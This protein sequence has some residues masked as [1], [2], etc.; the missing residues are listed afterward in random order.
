MASDF[1][2]IKNVEYDQNTAKYKFYDSN[3]NLIANTNDVI[4]SLSP[5]NC[6]IFNIVIDNPEPDR[7]DK[8]INIVNSL[9]FPEKS[10]I[11]YVKP[12]Q[13]P[14]SELLDVCGKKIKVDFSFKC[15]IEE[16][17][18]TIERK[19]EVKGF[20]SLIVNNLTI[21][22][23]FGC[24]ISVQLIKQKQNII[25]MFIDF[26]DDILRDDK[27]LKSFE[28]KYG[29]INNILNDNIEIILFDLKTISQLLT[30]EK[31]ILI[32]GKKIGESGRDFLK[33]LTLDIWAYKRSDEYVVPR[34]IKFYNNK[35]VRDMMIYLNNLSNFTK[36]KIIM[37]IDYFREDFNYNYEIGKKMGNIKV[38][39]DLFF[40]GLHLDLDLKED[41]KIDEEHVKEI[42]E[43]N[44]DKN[45][46]NK[47]YEDFIEY[48]SK[49]GIKIIK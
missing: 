32:R 6:N 31:D 30:E 27:Y 19:K 21:F 23:L 2:R 46:N 20:S 38:K 43:K 44:K 48:L 1:S 33:F 28:D 16:D 42:W 41:F 15:D 22:Y 47:K 8:I 40:L 35:Y 18:E 4:F 26:D 24:S 39:L 17:E 45:K 11:D 10:E 36:T 37:D 29:I 7:N 3:H 12:I 5:S 14:F 13:K 34:E 9:M 49:I 25:F